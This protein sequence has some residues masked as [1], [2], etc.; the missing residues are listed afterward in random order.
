MWADVL[1]IEMQLP[2]GFEKVLTR[3]VMELPSFDVNKVRALEGEIMMEIIRNCG[4]VEEQEEDSWSQNSG[5]GSNDFKP[6]MEDGLDKL[7][8]GLRSNDSNFV[9]R[10]VDD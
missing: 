1:T 8:S 7:S 5:P 3:N 9:R 4:V 6:C 2:G 10:T